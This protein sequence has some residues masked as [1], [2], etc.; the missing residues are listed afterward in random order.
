MPSNKSFRFVVCMC[1][2]CPLSQHCSPPP[3]PVTDP[4][5]SHIIITSTGP[6][7]PWPRSRTRTGPSRECLPA[8]VCMP[9]HTRAYA[10]PTCTTSTSTQA[11]TSAAVRLWE[12]LCLSLHAPPLSLPPS[13]PRSQPLDPLPHGQQD[14]VQRQEAPLV[15]VFGGVGVCSCGCVLAHSLSPAAAPSLCSLSTPYP[16]HYPTHCTHTTTPTLVLTGAAPSWA[17]RAP[18]GTVCSHN[19]GAHQWSSTHVEQLSASAAAASVC[20]AVVV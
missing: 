19:G 4:V 13:L 11:C 18:A 5:S 1:C 20:L 16:R 15:S 14:P 17:C 2:V 7:R 12:S 3:H 6:R 9:P 8:C 10:L